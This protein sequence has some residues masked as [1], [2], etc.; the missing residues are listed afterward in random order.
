VT[1]SSGQVGEFTINSPSGKLS[2]GD[3]E[4]SRYRM[5]CGNAGNGIVHLLGNS[6]DVD[7][8]YGMIQL[9]NSGNWEGY[10]CLD[11]IRIYGNGKVESYDGNGNVEWTR[12]LSNIPQG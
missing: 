11:G 4:L 3:A 1:A 10:T 2:V 7:A 5:S 12:Y 8:R 9:S 6:D